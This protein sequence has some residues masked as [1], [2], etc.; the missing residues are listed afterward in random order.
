MSTI[1]PSAGRKVSVAGWGYTSNNP[2][3]SITEIL[4]N[5][6][7]SVYDNSACDKILPT[8]QKDYDRQFCAGKI[9]ISKNIA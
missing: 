8:M 9:L 2:Y 6:Q 1:Y 4:Q 3:A 7:I 5:V